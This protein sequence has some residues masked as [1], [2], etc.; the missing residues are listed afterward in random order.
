[1]GSLPPANGGGGASSG[2]GDYPLPIFYQRAESVFATVAVA[3]AG[4]PRLCLSL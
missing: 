1:M 2:I 3:G 4:S